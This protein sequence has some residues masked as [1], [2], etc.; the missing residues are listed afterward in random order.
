VE[1][2][3]DTD[4]GDISSVANILAE[5]SDLAFSE[6]QPGVYDD[7]EEVSDDV[8]QINYDITSY[9]ADFPADMLVARL[10]N[11]DIV[12][13]KFQREF[14][15]TL[16]DASRFIESLILG[17]PVPGIFLSKD[18]ASRL[19][20]V[21]GQQRLRSLWAFF[22]NDFKGKSFALKKVHAMLEARRYKELDP[23]QRRM[24]DNALIHA[25]IFTQ[26]SPQDGES[27]TY[28]VF[29]RLNTGGRRLYPQEIRAAIHHTGGF[30]E[31]LK[32]FNEIPSWRAIYG[33]SKSERMK[34]VEL[35]LRFLALFHGSGNYEKPMKS[36]LNK[37]MADNATID[38]NSEEALRSLFETTIGYV[39]EALD[40]RAFKPLAAFNAAVFDSVM[41]GA[42]R[43]LAREP[44]PGPLGF[45]EAYDRLLQDV[46]FRA[47]YS[48]ATSDKESVSER[49][50]L[51]TQ[52]FEN[53]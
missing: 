35:I 37:Y 20:V 44:K 6:E 40:G 13:P 52:A 10:K 24:L 47:A 14:V 2:Q 21:D 32:S 34:D 25:T 28:S 15:W 51:A 46:S 27:A 31:A 45:V 41:V 11:G 50:R 17:L 53:L 9:G 49:L 42:A 1:Q 4:D 12:I 8:E 33:Q 23:E 48:K 39:Y 38:A 30:S 18:K 36:F 3:P 26:N 5:T 43:R 16:R 29:E 7:A 19:V 22:D